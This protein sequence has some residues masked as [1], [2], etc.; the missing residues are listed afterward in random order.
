M[1]V[2]RDLVSFEY[3]KIL[4]RKGAVTAVIIAVLLSAASVCGTM[5]GYIY[6]DGEPVMSKY[7]DMKADREYAHELSG[8]TLDGELIIEAARE[9]AKADTT[10]RGYVMSEEFRRYS[11]VYDIARQVYGCDFKE[12][13]ELTEEHAEQFYEVRRGNIE[14]YAEKSSMCE[15]SKQAVLAMDDKVSIPFEFQYAEGY[16]RFITIMYTT[17]IIALLV[18]AIVFAPLFSGEYTGGTDRL[19]LSSKH[20]KGLLVKAKLF[21]MMTFSAGYAIFVTLISFGECMLIW[22]ADGAQAPI[23]LSDPNSFYPMTMLQAAAAQSVSIFGACI[24]TGAVTAFLSAKMKT[25]FGA[26]I[27]MWVIIIAPMMMNVSERIVWVYDLFCL[28]PSNMTAVWFVLDSIQF[29]LF[30]QS[31]PPYIFM[32]VFAFIAAAAFSAAA[33]RTFGKKQVG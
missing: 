26:I 19:I 32:P 13:C 28:L 18:I 9:Y 7:E 1:S 17:G 30:G 10:D 15:A 25:P 20:G 8:R 24:M 6:I 33:Y 4:K 27:I 3:K 31:I 16:D 11:T 29:E 5:I 12:F 2:F 22:G 21:V 14:A 23:Q